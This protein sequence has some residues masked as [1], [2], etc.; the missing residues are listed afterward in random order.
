MVTIYGHAGYSFDKR[1]N[2][3]TFNE[4]RSVHRKNG[5]ALCN[6]LTRTVV[7]PFEQRCPIQFNN[8]L[9]A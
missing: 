9:R 8:R 1:V 4:A 3:G 7:M 5:R 2:L 6:A